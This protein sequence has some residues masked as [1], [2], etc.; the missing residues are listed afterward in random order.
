[1]AR[2][3]IFYFPIDTPIANDRVKLVPFDI[4]LH[5][6]AFIAQ[7]VTHPELY[8]NMSIVPFTTVAELKSA[9]NKPDTILSF[10]NPASHI[11]AIIDKTRDRSPEDP[12]GE[13]A[14][15]VSYIS[16]VPP[17]LSSE[18]GAIVVLPEYQ[19]SHVTS[20]AVGLLLQY[21]FAPADEG[22]LGLVRM[23]WYCSAANAASVKVAE[24]MGFQKVGLIPYHMKFPLGK[25]YGKLGNDRPLPPGSHPNDLWRDSLF[26]S[27]SWDVWEDEARDKVEKA[28]GR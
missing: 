3:Q 6:A 21:G 7:S 16:T 24:R 2:S 20:N 5:G 4:D 28:M 17:F 19:R 14:G 18:I 9:L 10:S 25:K 15:M 12:D 27:M 23:Q 26:Y 11:F 13:L 22:G 1:M 8:A